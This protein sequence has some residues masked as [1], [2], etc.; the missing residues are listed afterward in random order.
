MSNITYWWVLDLCDATRP[1]YIARRTHNL[2]V[3]AW[4]TRDE[5]FM[6]KDFISK[7]KLITQIEEPKL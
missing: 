7:F 4:K 5:I 6:H 3:I 2:W 1:K